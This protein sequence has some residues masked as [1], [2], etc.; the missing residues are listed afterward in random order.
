MMLMLLEW[1]GYSG[2]PG[3]M[4]DKTR[5]DRTTSPVSWTPPDGIVG[6][7]WCE[8]TRRLHSPFPFSHTDRART[9][10]VYR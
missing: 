4:P 5:A 2:K 8:S 9:Q 7:D 3:I 6:C 10:I 1:E